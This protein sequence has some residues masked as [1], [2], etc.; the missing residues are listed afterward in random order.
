MRPSGVDSLL[1]KKKINRYPC[2]IPKHAT[3]TSLKKNKYDSSNAQYYERAN[4]ELGIFPETCL[5]R[6]ARLTK[7]K[8]ECD[9]LQRYGENL[10]KESDERRVKWANERPWYIK[11]YHVLVDGKRNYIS[12]KEKEY[13]NNKTKA[14]AQS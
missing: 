11:I 4:R 9:K 14:L 10:I 6:I 7:F 5:E 13:Y 3:L 1:N 2:R 8:E 12:R